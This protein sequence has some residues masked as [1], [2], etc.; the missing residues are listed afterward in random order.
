MKIFFSHS[1]RD[2]PLV[3]EI[4]KSLPEHIKSWI[5]EKELL[6]GDDLKDSIKNQFCPVRKKQAVTACLL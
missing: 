5:D 4:Q 1:S 2:K 3:R 6:I